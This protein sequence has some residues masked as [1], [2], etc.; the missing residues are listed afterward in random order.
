MSLNYPLDVKFQYRVYRLGELNLLQP[1]SSRSQRFY[2]HI[3]CGPDD[4]HMHEEYVLDSYE[5]DVEGRCVI[6]NI[7]QSSHQVS[8]SFT[9]H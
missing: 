7:Q 3:S 5:A 2:D 6:V 9:A 8:T 1:L 4:L